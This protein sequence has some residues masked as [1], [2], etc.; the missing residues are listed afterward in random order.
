MKLANISAD[1]TGIN[2]Y[3]DIGNLAWPLYQ[4]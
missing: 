2:K 3:E 1:I 4:G